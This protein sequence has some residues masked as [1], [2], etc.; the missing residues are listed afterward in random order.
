MWFAMFVTM[1]A[2]TKLLPEKHHYISL[3]G[4]VGYAS[5]LNNLE[6]VS[7]GPGIA[8]SIGIG[9]H[10]HYNNFICQLAFAGEYAFHTNKIP[11][12]DLII[13]MIDTE[14][15]PFDLHA[16]V[17]DGR[18]ALH[19]I[20]IQI[21]LLIGCEYKKFYFLAGAKFGLNM[22][23][24]TR[25]QSLLSTKGDYDRYIDHF[26]NMPNH[27]FQE[28]QMVQSDSYEFRFKPSVNLH[29]EIGGRIGTFSLAKGADVMVHKIRYYLAAFVDYGVLNVHQNKAY[30]S[31]LGYQQTEDK[32]LQFY[33]LPSMVSDIM[34]DAQVHPLTVGI[35]FTALFELPQTKPC[36]MCVH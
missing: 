16:A 29:A 21:P 6:T 32:G 27:F 7:S 1:V 26:E 3:Y 13:P 33:V 28:G 5:L 14:L 19:S 10:V 9:Y 20:Q 8:P 22:F 4:E 31:A 23:G 11:N 24:K 34:K 30:G 17:S 35:K 12:A 2:A 15:H 18:D 36:V 25:S